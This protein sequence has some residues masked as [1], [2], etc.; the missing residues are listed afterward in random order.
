MDELALA[1]ELGFSQAAPLAMEALAPNAQVRAM[2][3]ADRCGMYGRSWSCPPGCGTLGRLEREMK[4]YARGLLVQTTAPLE[5]EFDAAGMEQAR[6]RHRR[7]FEALVRCLRRSGQQDC[8]PLT[9]GACRVCL[10]CTY[11]GAPC[12]FPQK[13]MASIAACWSARCAAARDWVIFT[14][15]TPSPTPPACCCGAEKAPG[16]GRPTARGEAPR[17]EGRP[18]AGEWPPARGNA[19]GK[20]EC[21][22][23][24][25]APGK[26][27]A[28]GKGRPRRG[29]PPARGGPGGGGPRR[30]EAPAGEWPQFSERNPLP[31]GKLQGTGEKCPAGE[32]ALCGRERRDTKQK[33]SV[34][35]GDTKG[36]LF[37][38]A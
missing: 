32:P 21:P 11:P 25:N 33:G 18:P 26:R 37:E 10:S 27:E 7:S 6:T 3:A 4:G 14:G 23:R 13:R 16:G 19:P 24:G 8:L 22:R 1:L 9:A 29:M 38:F 2:C 17:R 34:C 36:A 28:P 15:R 31:V 30:G 12:R 5:D 35:H 20:R